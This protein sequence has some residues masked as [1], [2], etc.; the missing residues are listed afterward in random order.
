MFKM[1]N[2]LE[3]LK[4]QNGKTGSSHSMVKKVKGRSGRVANA[5]KPEEW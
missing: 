4:R 1:V 3:A 5:I 2:A